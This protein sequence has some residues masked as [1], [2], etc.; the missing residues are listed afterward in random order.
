MDEEC[1]QRRH[2][3]QQQEIVGWEELDQLEDYREVE[4]RLEC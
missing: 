1:L 3:D 4:W 2:E